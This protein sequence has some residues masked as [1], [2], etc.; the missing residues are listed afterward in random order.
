[1]AFPDE[2]LTDEEEVVLHL[3]PHARAAIGPILVLLAGLAAVILVWV[4]LP[5][6]TGG[7]IG[8]LIVAAIALFTGLTRG[9]WPLLVWRTTHYVFT[10]ERIL[11]QDGVIARAR[12][13]LPLNRVNDHALR[14]TL[15]DRMLGSGTLKIDSIGEQVAV[16][17]SVPGAHRVQTLLYQLIETDRELRGDGDDEEPA[18]DEAPQPTA[19]QRGAERRSLSPT[20]R[21]GSRRPRR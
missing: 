16:L 11:L 5:P 3:H 12:R 2:I 7:L 14:Q 10:D 6:T 1:M 20:P 9:V 13:D 21:P 17:T 15:L 8:V 18:E 19:R 4:M